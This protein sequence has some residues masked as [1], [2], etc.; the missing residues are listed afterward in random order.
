MR[1]CRSNDC[2]QILL[3]YSQ[4]R[5]GYYDVDLDCGDYDYTDEPCPGLTEQIWT[6]DINSTSLILQCGDARVFSLDHA[7]DWLMCVT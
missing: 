1:V 3:W 4:K 2:Q 5:D 6:V 7:G